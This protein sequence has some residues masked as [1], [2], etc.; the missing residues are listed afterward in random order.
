VGDRYFD[1][2]SRFGA[3]NSRCHSHEHGRRF[4]AVSRCK[5]DTHIGTGVR[6]TDAAGVGWPIRFCY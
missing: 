4:T 1:V 2:L 3:I 6:S 5:Q